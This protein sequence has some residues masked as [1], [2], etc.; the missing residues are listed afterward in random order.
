MFSYNSTHGWCTSCF[1]TGKLL[2]DFDDEQSGE[3]AYWLDTQEAQPCPDCEGQRLCEESLHVF[4]KKR[5]IADFASLSVGD[6]HRA[7]ETLQLNARE[8][9]IARDVLTELTNRL[10]FLNDVGLSYLT[11]DRSA[12]SLSGGEAQRIRLAAQLGS[13]LRGVCYILDEP[14]IGLHPR[15][16]R[17]LLDTLDKL[18]N[19]GNTIVV[20]EHDE[21]T[22]RQADHVIDVGPGAGVRGGE[23]VATGTVSQIER[24]KGSITGQWLAKPLTHPLTSKRRTVNNTL[25]VIGA[26]QNNLKNIDVE[27]P[28]N[29]LVCVSGVSGSGK[30]SLIRDVVHDNLRPINAMKRRRNISRWSGCERIDGWEPLS[31]VLE[32][33]QTPIGKTPRSCPATYIGFWDNIRRVFSEATEARIRG[34]TPSRFSFNVKGGRCAECDGQGVKRIEM[35]FLPDVKVACEV[36]NGQR[37]NGETLSVRYRDQSI[38]DV[39]AM[40]VDTA[41]EFFQAHTNIHHPLRLLQDVG[42]G[43][44][45]LGQQSPTL[46]GGEAQRVKLVAELAKAK[47]VLKDKRG[48]N[49]SASHTLYVLD[50]PTV[51]LHMADVAKL[52]QVLHQLVESGNSVIVIEH[53]LDLMAEADWLID[54]GPEGG[55]AGGRVVAAGTPEKVSRSRRSR[56]APYLK[57]V[58]LPAKKVSHRKGHVPA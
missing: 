42:L 15:D 28:L 57:D 52:I 21:D 35:N 55:D 18:G 56:T 22:I 30:S 7:F 46:S 9:L 49:L 2:V 39:L 24:N 1:G 50:E 11:L 58:L 8:S 13:N 44:L 54:V 14:T 47:P 48:R 37:F 20:V 25:S 45:T 12:P 29:A 51:G 17:M 3:E 40:D 27:L 26:S 36:C 23:I 19:K 38:G 32:V 10:H 4:F 16:N 6:A 33:D 31:R 53:N 5:S 43:Y 41:V 34:Y